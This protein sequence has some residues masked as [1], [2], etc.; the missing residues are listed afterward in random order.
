MPRRQVTERRV[1]RRLRRGRRPHH[2]RAAEGAGVAGVRP[3]NPVVRDMDVQ[4]SSRRRWWRR[5]DE[6]GGVAGADQGHVHRV[7]GRRGA[8]LQ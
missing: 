5:R 3:A 4:S 6:A 1:V 2:G 8:D 7:P